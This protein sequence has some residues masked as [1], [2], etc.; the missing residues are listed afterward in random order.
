MANSITSCQA[1]QLLALQRDLM[2]SGLIVTVGE[3]AT[4]CATTTTATRTRATTRKAATRATTADT[5]DTTPKR[6]GRPPKTATT[7]ATTAAGTRKMSKAG[8]K[9]IAGASSAYH[10]RIRELRDTEHLTHKQARARYQ[11][12]KEAGT[13]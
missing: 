13:L 2:E 11:E 8:R 4:S 1:N 6:R 12:L 7:D 10:A 9:A 5:T 3:C